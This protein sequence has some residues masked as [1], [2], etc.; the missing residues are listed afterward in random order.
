MRIGAAGALL[1][2]VTTAC[3][4]SLFRQYEYEEDLYL[5]LDG[6]AT[7]YVNGSLDALNALRGTRLDA[8]PDAPPDRAAIERFFTSPTTTVTRVTTSERGGR[9]FVHVRVDVADV[10]TL[11]DQRPFAWSA[12]EFGR[13]G[14]LVIYTQRVGPRPAG[15]EPDE[16]LPGD[17]IV[18]FRLHAPSRVVYHNAGADNQRRGNILVWEQ[19]LADRVAGVPVVIEARMEPESILYQTLWLFGASALAVAASFA[20]VIWWL[21]RRR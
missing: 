5:S 17:A 9:R 12:Y 14:D 2:A 10:R 8:D 15:T 3:G 19:A 16:R 1:L 13:D 11:G 21:T 4:T 6:T 20:V 18:A 7:L